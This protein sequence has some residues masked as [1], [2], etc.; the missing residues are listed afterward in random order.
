[1]ALTIA[2]PPLSPADGHHPAPRQP[3]EAPG[4]PAARRLE[5]AGQ[6]AGQG[7]KGSGAAAVR[8]SARRQPAGQCC[9]VVCVAECC[10]MQCNRAKPL[11]VR[12]CAA[13]WHNGTDSNPGFTLI[14]LKCLAAAAAPAGAHGGRAASAGAA[15]AAGTP[16]D[17]L[18]GWPP[19]CTASWKASRSSMRSLPMQQQ[20]QQGAA[21][22][23]GRLGMDGLAC[24]SLPPFA[25]AQPAAADG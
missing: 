16:Q 15:A 25:A 11:A 12:C 20:Q 10:A 2:R 5:P 18:G 4:S 17:C 6:A 22:C 24:S 14:R 21:V 19:S 1:M 13:G 8:C 23:S 7:I 9:G 3:Q